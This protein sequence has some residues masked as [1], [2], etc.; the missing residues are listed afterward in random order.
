MPARISAR[1]AKLASTRTKNGLPSFLS[2]DQRG[3]THHI[4]E[5]KFGIELGNGGAKRRSQSR[6]IASCPEH[7][8]NRKKWAVAEMAHK[9]WIIDDAFGISLHV[10]DNSDDLAS[11]GMQCRYRLIEFVCR[12]DSDREND[13]SR[14]LIHY[15]HPTGLWSVLFG[16]CA[17]PQQRD[18]GSTKE[19]GGTTLSLAVSCWLAGTSGWPWTRNVTVLGPAAGKSEVAAAAST[20]G[21]CASCGIRLRTKRLC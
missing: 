1:N 15:D 4:C 7:Q 8:R 11:T 6:G 3:H 12:A 5:R 20:P 21:S 9:L 13:D 18:S 10:A 19:I 2:I 17:A 14:F 16:D